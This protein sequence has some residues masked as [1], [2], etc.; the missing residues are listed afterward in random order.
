MDLYNSEILSY[1]I[2]TRPTLDIVINP[3]NSIINQRPNLN[4]RMTIH[5]DQGWHYQ[6]KAYTNKLKE[7]KIFQ[8][9]SRKANCLDNSLMEN[10][11]GLLKQ[12]MFYGKTYDSF[13]QLESAI[14][15]YINFYNNTRIKTKLKGLS[16]MQYRKQTFE[17][18]Y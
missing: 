6:H 14:H 3:L 10:F 1:C 15:E 8:S 18:L 2:S 16:P 13:Q 17:I 9:M 5:S 4:Y 7:N 11:F 12:E